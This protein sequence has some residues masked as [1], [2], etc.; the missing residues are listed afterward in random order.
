MNEMLPARYSWIVLIVPLLLVSCSS[1]TGPDGPPPPPTSKVGGV[2]RIDG[3]PAPMAQVVFNL[4]PI[5]RDRKPGERLP[6]CLVRDDGQFAFSSYRDGDGAEP[7]EYVLT[8]EWLRIALAGRFGPDKFLNN[9]NSPEVNKDDPRFQ[10]TVVEGQP[11]EIATIEITTSDLEPK[12]MH[13]YA[14][15]KGKKR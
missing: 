5:G 15:P 14:T 3:K 1:T 6:Q 8:M 11:T 7:G 13:Q 2:V 10:V 12:P 9:F 4:Y